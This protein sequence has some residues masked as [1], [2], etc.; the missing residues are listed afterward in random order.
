MGGLNLDDTRYS[1]RRAIG[2]MRA[3]FLIVD[4]MHGNVRNR[5]VLYSERISLSLTEEN[6]LI[7]QDIN[8][9]TTVNAHI[10]VQIP[11]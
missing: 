1:W 8:I 7:H 9:L 4:I 6:S 2:S 10:P 5:L 11:K 3:D